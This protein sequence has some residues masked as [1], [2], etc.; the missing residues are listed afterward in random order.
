MHRIAGRSDS[1]VAHVVPSL[2]SVAF[3]RYR[4]F[5]DFY[6]LLVRAELR[7][8]FPPVRDP[9]PLFVFQIEHSIT[10]ALLDFLPSYKFWF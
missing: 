3:W 4:A 8:H 1:G 6:D 5:E 9:R 7:A 2:F 10:V